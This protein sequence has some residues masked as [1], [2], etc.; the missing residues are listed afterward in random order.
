MANDLNKLNDAL[1][2]TLE[3]VRKGEM[4]IEKAQTVVNLGTTIIN[5]AKVQVAA[6]KLSKGQ[7][8]IA[9]LGRNNDEPIAIGNVRDL[10][11][12]IVAQELAKEKGYINVAEAMI[13]YGK[14][15]FLKEVE[16]KI[17]G[18]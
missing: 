15:R 18:E 5:T 4:R 12:T 3:K 11:N 8:S 7:T 1:F 2:D 17:Y 9:L 10:E 6:F 13:A 14:E 16:I